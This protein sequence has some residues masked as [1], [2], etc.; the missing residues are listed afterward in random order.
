[1]PV[2]QLNFQ[3]FQIGTQVPDNMHGKAP[4]DPSAWAS[5]TRLRAQ[6]FPGLGLGLMQHSLSNPAAHL[7]NEA[8]HGRCLSLPLSLSTSLPLFLSL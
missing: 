8:V 2:C 4:N 6:G 1:M 7:G 5:V 3:L